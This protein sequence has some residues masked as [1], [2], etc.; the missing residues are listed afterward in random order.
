MWGT[1]AVPRKIDLRQR[2]DQ[3]LP[4]ALGETTGDDQVR[5]GA[6][7]RLLPGGHAEDLRDRLLPGG[8]DEGAGVDHDDRSLFRA[9]RQEIAGFGEDARHDLGIDQILGTAEAD[10]VDFFCMHF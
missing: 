7:A 8:K 10:D 4:V 5:A 1:S 6:A 3:L 9:V 2:L